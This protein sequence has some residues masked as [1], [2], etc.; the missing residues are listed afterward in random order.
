MGSRLLGVRTLTRLC[1]ASHRP[2]HLGRR[3][4]A[5][6]AGLSPAGSMG[7]YLNR[8]DTSCAS[9]GCGVYADFGQA[10]DFTQPESS[11]GNSS[12][13]ADNICLGLILDE[14]DDGG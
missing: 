11:L 8:S 14:D 13:I 2:A 1:N 5:S 6:M 3:T 4:L 10:L 9:N 12:R 7:S